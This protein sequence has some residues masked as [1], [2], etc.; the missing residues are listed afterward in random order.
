MPEHT[1]NV[2]YFKLL[3]NF[4]SEGFSSIHEVLRRNRLRI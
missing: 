2:V 1:W 4:K 3:Q